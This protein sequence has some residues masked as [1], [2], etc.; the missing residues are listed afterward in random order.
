MKRLE[1]KLNKEKSDKLRLMKVGYEFQ[2]KV[3]EFEKVVVEKDE[4]LLR[5]GKE[6]VEVIR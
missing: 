4:G 5:L 3:V 6:K 2:K 1:A